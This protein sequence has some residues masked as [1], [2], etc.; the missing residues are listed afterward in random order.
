MG[1]STI[2]G[3]AAAAAAAVAAAYVVLRPR[4]EAP[5]PA[6]STMSAVVARDSKCTLQQQWAVPT[7]ADGEVQ[8]R[9][10]ATAVNRLDC[11]QRS[12]KLPVPP[13]V[14]EVLGLE[15]AGVVVATGAG[16]GGFATG[17]EVLA[18]LPGGGYSEYACV[19]VATVV[20]KPA[21]LSWSAAASVSEVWL[22]AL[23]LVHLVGRVEAGD[24]VLIHAAASGVGLAAIQLVVAAG[25]RAIVT[26]GSKEKLAQCVALGALGGAVRHD[27]PWLDKITSL[28]PDGKSG[29]DVVLDPVASGYAKQNLESLGVDGRWVLYSVLTGPAL[30]EDVAK[31]FLGVMA[32]K[33]ISLLA[34][35]LR[36]RPKAYKKHLMARFAKEVLPRLASGALVHV[37]DREF[38]GLDQA[39]AAHEYM[40]SNAGSGKLVLKVSQREA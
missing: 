17:D 10:K 35:T 34:T 3:G 29:V 25:A 15:A 18:L 6:P 4:G 16:V 5:L 1:Y 20:H 26:V 23:K 11:L 8:I 38:D 9:I 21:A 28:L 24:V 31:T 40:E 12:G 22:T 19:D 30:P 33:R 32:R 37:I 39:Q 13:G 2:L 14:T 27:G 7:P 36:T